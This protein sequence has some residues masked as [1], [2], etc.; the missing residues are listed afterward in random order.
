LRCTQ[1]RLCFAYPR[2]V[3]EIGLVATMARL[4][5]VEVIQMQPPY[6]GRRKPRS[7]PYDGELYW[8]ADV[9]RSFEAL[10]QTLFDARVLLSILES[11]RTGPVG[12]TG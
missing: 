12:V 3:E 10:R 8:T 11:E 2:L 4:L 9:V 7:S 6:H 5:K 1:D